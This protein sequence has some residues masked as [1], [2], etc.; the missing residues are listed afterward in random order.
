MIVQDEDLHIM[1]GYLPSGFYFCEEFYGT[2]ECFVFSF[3]E[4]ERKLKVYNAYN[5]ENRFYI[6]SNHFFIGLG[7]EYSLSLFSLILLLPMSQCSPFPALMIDDNL[8]SGETRECK[9]FASPPLSKRENF[10]VKSIEFW[11]FK[12][13]V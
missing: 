7:Y 1:G 4:H 5:G 11:T 3:D 8:L 13:M 12:I 10:R 6:F 2:P 9:T